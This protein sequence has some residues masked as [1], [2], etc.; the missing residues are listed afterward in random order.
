LSFEIKV[1]TYSLH[2]YG[3]WW[4]RLIGLTKITLK[5][6]LGRAF[7]SYESHHTILTEIKAELCDRPLTYVGSSP[8]NTDPLTPA[9]LI[10]GRR[11]TGMPYHDDPAYVIRRSSTVTS[12]HSR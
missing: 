2:W 1:E 7:V 10:Y 11:L 4:E 6:V 9:H 12:D 8:D 3:G 5:K